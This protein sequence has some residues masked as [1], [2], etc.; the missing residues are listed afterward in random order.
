MKKLIFFA[1][2]IISIIIL[3]L[4]IDQRDLNMKKDKFKKEN[5]IIKK[6]VVAGSFYPESKEE[7]AILVD[8]LL[9]GADSVNGDIRGLIVPHAGYVFSGQTAASGYKALIGRGFDTVVLIGNS[10]QEF[11]DGISV[12]KEGFYETP[13]GRIEIDSVFAN[14]LIES[15]DKIFFKE[16]AHSNEHSLEVQLPFLQRALDDFKII[17]I[18]LGNKN[19]SVDVLISSLKELI[20]EK[21]I[22]IASS[23]LSHYPSEEDAQYSDGKVIEAILTG[24]RNNLNQAIIDIEK[25]N[26]SGLETCACGR[27]SIEVVMELNKDKEARLL[28]YTNS[29]QGGDGSFPVDKSRVVGY[30]SIGFFEKEFSDGLSEEEKERLLE[31][32]KK[33]VESYVSAGKI[34]SFSEKGIL[35]KNLGAF[36]TIKKNGQLRGC[37]GSFSPDI[38]LYQVVSEM[39][40]SA[41]VNDPRFSPVNE[42]ELSDLDYEISV[43]SPLKK[44]DSW[45]DVEIGKHGVQVVKDDRSGVFLPQVAVE[46][47]WDLETFMNILCQQKAGL[48]ADCWKD[49]ST[50]IYTFTA[51]VFGE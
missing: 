14:K 51:N 24:D 25:Q 21:T 18:I 26:I 49:S 40:I 12:Y 39:A 47:N 42:D 35:N 15:S 31:I 27:G 4:V 10:H 50:D 16:S 41:A 17:P 7:L 30:A 28:K 45:K 36:V 29:G 5:N 33:S 9:E 34:L 46:N 43:L 19:D 37:I 2:L 32:A 8:K 23:D 20:D 13:L 38:P 1:I 44:V 11:F 22:I 6:A 3:T 48:P